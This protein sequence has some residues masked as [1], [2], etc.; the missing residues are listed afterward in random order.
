MRKTFETALENLFDN[1]K[2]TQ[3]L[4]VELTLVSESEVIV[5]IVRNRLNQNKTTSQKREQKVS[6]HSALRKELEYELV[7]KSHKS[8]LI[9]FR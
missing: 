4:N 7:R 1:R 2:L 5:R 8:E 9:R 3:K 6:M